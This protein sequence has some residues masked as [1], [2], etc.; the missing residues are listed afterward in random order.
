MQTLEI[1]SRKTRTVNRGV[2]SKARSRRRN[3]T[4]INLPKGVIRAALREIGPAPIKLAA[5]AWKTGW[6]QLAALAPQSKNWD[7]GVVMAAI[8]SL[9][10]GRPGIVEFWE[11]VRDDVLGWPTL[12]L[13]AIAALAKTQ[14]GRRPQRRA[15]LALFAAFC[16]CEHRSERHFTVTK[17]LD[18]REPFGPYRVQALQATFVGLIRNSYRVPKKVDYLYRYK[19]IHVRLATGKRSTV[20]LEPEFYEQVSSIIGERMTCQIAKAVAASYD[21]SRETLKV[22][23]CVQQELLALIRDHLPSAQLLGIK[24]P[25]RFVKGITHRRS[26]ERALKSQ[27][28]TRLSWRERKAR[29]GTGYGKTWRTVNAG[30]VQGKYTSIYISITL[31]EGSQRAG[32]RRYR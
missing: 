28:T 24:D 18:E 31:Y 17:L 14:G 3:G 13:Q 23:K 27:G 15:E 19:V 26:Y 22:S 21:P 30:K 8:V 9:A 6:Q 2:K 25:Q 5:V 20:S 1:R 29:W 32:C 11:D 12:M 10:E 16:Y 7:V 4:Q